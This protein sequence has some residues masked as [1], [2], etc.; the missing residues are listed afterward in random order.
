LAEYHDVHQIMTRR[1]L[2]FVALSATAVGFASLV[3]LPVAAWADA[4]PSGVSPELIALCRLA[5][6]LPAWIVVGAAFLLI[7]RPGGWRAIWS[8]GGVLLTSVVCSGASAELL[9]IIVR[10]ERPMPPFTGYVFRPWSVQTWSS[11][12]L[13]WPS[14]HV[15]VAFGAVWA[16]WY[17]HPR[18][19]AVWLLVGCGCAWSRLAFH[20]HFLSDV[21]GATFVA[22]AVTRGVVALP[23]AGGGRSRA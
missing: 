10:R 14:S 22:Y 18:A 7:D 21:V 20:D 12:G 5:G 1:V 4:H 19:R 23:Q 17:L 9:K 2:V 6:Y 3:D 16:L 11:S 13:G 8:R 15:A